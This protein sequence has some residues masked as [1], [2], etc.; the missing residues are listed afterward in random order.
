M[1]KLK[2]ACIGLP[3]RVDTFKIKLMED[4]SFQIHLNNG[5]NK[6]GKIRL[7]QVQV[8]QLMDYLHNN[9]K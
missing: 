2:S 3:D 4:G 5:D 7:S 8:K 9:L 6:Y 1:L